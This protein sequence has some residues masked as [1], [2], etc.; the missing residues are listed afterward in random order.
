MPSEN[1]IMSGIMMILLRENCWPM[2]L[3]GGSCDTNH[4]GVGGFQ[5]F[6]Q[7]EAVAGCT[8]YRSRLTKN[9]K[10]KTHNLNTKYQILNTSLV[11]QTNSKQKTHNLNTKFT[12]KGA[13]DTTLTF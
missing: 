4:E 13:K 8:K 3:L 11:T 6:H 7:M 2:V 9:L 12:K 10:Q 5:E 1:S